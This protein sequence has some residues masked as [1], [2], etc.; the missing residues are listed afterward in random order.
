MQSAYFYRIC[1][2]F[3]NIES[4]QPLKVIKSNW[5][6]ELNPQSIGDW[7]LSLKDWAFS[8]VQHYTHYNNHSHSLR[9]IRV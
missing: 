5:K 6:G 8:E 4:I 1:S 9:Y 7:K 2:S 3:E